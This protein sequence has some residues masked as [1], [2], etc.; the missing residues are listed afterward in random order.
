[1]C[2]CPL[3]ELK[4]LVSWSMVRKG[5]FSSNRKETRAYLIRDLQMECDCKLLEIMRIKIYM[6]ILKLIALGNTVRKKDS[7]RIMNK[8][9]WQHF[10]VFYCVATEEP[11]WTWLERAVRSHSSMQ[12]TE[13]GKCSVC[14]SKSALRL[15]LCNLPGSSSLHNT[16]LLT[17]LRK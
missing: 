1:M 14:R 6:L 15:W 4:L 5:S 3:S 16:R 2:N 7:M 10:P 9:P 12:V 17:S 11:C 13:T 8:E